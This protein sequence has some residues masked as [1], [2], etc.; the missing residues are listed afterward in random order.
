MLLTILRKN[1]DNLINICTEEIEF[2]KTHRNPNN[3]KQKERKKG[4]HVAIRTLDGREGEVIGLGGGSIF[5][6]LLLVLLLFPF[7]FAAV[8]GESFFLFVLLLFSRIYAK[9][10]APKEGEGEE[11]GRVLWGRRREFVT[12]PPP[13]LFS[14]FQRE[15]KEEENPPYLQVE[16]GGKG[17][18]AKESRFMGREKEEG[19]RGGQNLLHGILKTGDKLLL[20]KLS[21]I[22]RGKRKNPLLAGSK[23]KKNLFWL[24]SLRK[25]G[26]GGAQ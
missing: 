3:N 11:G 1:A 6:L 24:F 12:T 19:G 10:E 5:A 2:G 14:L 26:G 13:P 4:C 16:R 23:R 20:L 15:G 22:F 25:Q 8:G 21:E 18:V 17:W 9:G 7:S